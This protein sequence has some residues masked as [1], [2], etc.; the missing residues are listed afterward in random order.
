MSQ[1]IATPTAQIAYP[2]GTI[3]TPWTVLIKGTNADGSPFEDTISSATPSITYNLPVGV[4]TA[5]ISKNGV[6]CQESNQF[7]VSAPTTVLLTVPDA[8]QQATITSA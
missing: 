4:F 1:V 6:S 5:V 2:F 3:D 8:T 7:T